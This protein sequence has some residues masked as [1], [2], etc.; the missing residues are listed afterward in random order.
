MF[1]IYF[2]AVPYGFFNLALIALW[3]ASGFW[4]GL[5]VLVFETRA[6]RRGEISEDSPR[7][8]YSLLV[9]PTWN[10]S[11]PPLWTLFHPLNVESRNIYDQRVTANDPNAGE[12]NQNQNNDVNEEPSM[13]IN[14]LGINI[15]FSG[16]ERALHDE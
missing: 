3:A 10:R 7:G 4:M 14:S 9:N 2:L 15:S 5:F 12:G 11:L 6:L 16:M 8:Y 13:T 1:Q